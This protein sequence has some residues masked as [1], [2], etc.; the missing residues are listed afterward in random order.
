MNIM[1]RCIDDLYMHIYSKKKVS[2]TPTHSPLVLWWQLYILYQ[3]K[4]TIIFFPPNFIPRR[5]RREK[6]KRKE[7]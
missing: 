1:D 7:S 4:N 6:E 3:R 5:R 2:K